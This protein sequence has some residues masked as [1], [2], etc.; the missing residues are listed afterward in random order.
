[1]RDEGQAAGS[2]RNH[3]LRLSRSDP[4]APALVEAIH[5]GEVGSLTVLLREHPGL[6]ASRLVDEKGGSGRPLHAV[7]DWPG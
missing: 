1:M 5:A 6:A 3:Q 7:T 4:V 2:T